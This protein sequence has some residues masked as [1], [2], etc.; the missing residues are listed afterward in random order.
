MK[1]NINSAHPPLTANIKANKSST[2]PKGIFHASLIKSTNKNIAKSTT[3]K[4]ITI[5]G[6]RRGFVL[7]IPTILDSSPRTV[8][9]AGAPSSDMN[10]DSSEIILF[11]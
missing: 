5:I 6:I 9:R 4:R 8:A 7:S 2:I 1:A 11:V 10:D 3:I